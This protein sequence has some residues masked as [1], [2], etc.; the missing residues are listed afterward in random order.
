MPYDEDPHS[1][2]TRMLDQL[3]AAAKT[4]S[5]LRVLQQAEAMGLPEEVM[6]L[7]T[8]LPPGEFTRRR[9]VDQLNSAI[10]G[11][12]MGRSLGTFD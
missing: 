4:V 8:L 12:G 10:V 9:L 6:A 1:L 5:R 3:Y 2:V 7:F 11:H